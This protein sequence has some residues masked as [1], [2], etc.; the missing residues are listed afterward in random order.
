MLKLTMTPQ[1]IAQAVQGAVERF[2]GMVDP[3]EL[4]FSA[5]VDARLPV[6]HDTH[7]LHSV[8]LNLLINAFKYTGKQKQIGV[9]AF[10]GDDDCVHI[11]V[12]DNGI[13]LSPVEA[14]RVFQ[15]FY[16]VENPA[17]NASGV[18]L[19]LAIAHYLITRHHGT[20]TVRSEQGKGSTFRITLPAS[21]ADSDSPLSS[22][23]DRTST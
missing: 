5:A 6:R 2:Q 21:H 19:G 7:A 12:S 4:T 16:R 10:D 13:G 15:P 11:E 1:P 17:A 3:E 9:R 14:K 23:M 20:I 8:V 18:G 22:S